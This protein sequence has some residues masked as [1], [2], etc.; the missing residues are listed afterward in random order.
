MLVLR[1][2]S[3][4]L[5]TFSCSP[6]SRHEGESFYS[7]FMQFWC[8]QRPIGSSMF[9]G[10]C[11][12]LNKLPFHCFGSKTDVVEN[13]RPEMRRFSWA[14]VESPGARESITKRKSFA[15]SISGDKK[16]SE[17]NNKKLRDAILLRFF[18]LQLKCFS[19]SNDDDE[20]L[21]D[22]HMAAFLSVYRNNIHGNDF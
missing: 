14:D 3:F 13:P 19:P 18:F 2:P 10:R 15:R 9:A 7:S 20:W 11:R 5:P 6:S 17:T 1:V 22:N 21:D 4:F 8:Q 16:L 12:D